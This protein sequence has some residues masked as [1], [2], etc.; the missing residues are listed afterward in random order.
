MNIKS[1]KD[2]TWRAGL[3]RR[4]VRK[5]FLYLYLPIALL[6]LVGSAAVFALHFQQSEDVLLNRESAKLKT[7][8]TGIH[9]DL[10]VVIRDLQYLV[11]DDDLAI[12]IRS[13]TQLQTT[14]LQ[15]RFANFGKAKGLY[16]QIRYIDQNGDERVRV[17]FVDQTPIFVPQGELQNKSDRYYFT[18]SR[19]L[20]A[21]AVFISRFDLNIEHDQVE[22]PRKPMLRFV[23]PV[24]V[25]G[26]RQGVMVIDY[27]AEHILRQI[28]RTFLH[29]DSAGYLL[30]ANGDWLIGPN[31]HAER[32]IMDGRQERFQDLYPEAWDLLVSRSKI[33]RTDD[34]LFSMM[35]VAPPQEVVKSEYSDAFWAIVS[36]IDA[37]DFYTRQIVGKLP[38][39]GVVGM[40]LIIF[41][42]M[43][44][45]VAQT[46]ALR[47]EMD[48][49][50]NLHLVDALNESEHR[51]AAVIEA[52]DDVIMTCTENGSIRHV[53]HAAEKVFRLAQVDLE[54]RNFTEFLMDPDTISTRRNDGRLSLHE[55]E[56][57]E[58]YAVRGTGEGFPA[59]ITVTPIPSEKGT[60]FSLFIR[61]ITLRRSFEERLKRLANY[62][63]LTGLANQVLLLDHINEVLPENDGADGPYAVIMGDLDDFRIMNDTLGHVI[64]DEALKEVATRIHKI[65]PSGSLS[66]RFGGDEFVIVLPCRGD[67]ALPG[68]V[69]D[70]ILNAFENPLEVGGYRLYVGIS[71]GV[72]LAESVEATATGLL[73][74]ADAAMYASKSAGRNTFRIFTQDMQEES[75]RLLAIQT[76]LAGARERGD[77][78]LYFQ[79]LVDAKTSRIIGAEALLRWTDAELGSVGPAEFVPVAESTGLIIDFGE[80]ALDKACR[81][82]K[83]WREHMPEFHVAV[84]ISPVQL[85][86]SDVVSTIKTPLL[87]HALAP[88][89]LEVEITEGL[90]IKD[91]KEAEKTLNDLA[92]IGVPISIDDFGTGYSS[93][94]YLHRYP[95]ATLKI[96][97]MFVMGLP[98][99]EDSRSLVTTVLALAER[100]NLKVVAEGVETQGQSE[101]LSEHGC[102]IL[103]GYLYGKP[104]ALEA[105]NALVENRSPD[106][107]GQ[108]G[109][110]G[111][112]LKLV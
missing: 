28:R 21:G 65:A 109:A 42:Y 82:A 29:S 107:V 106:A 95:F 77:I 1:P 54:G 39:L 22:M 25:D 51:N 79:P 20:S 53:N 80:W 27:L 57:F 86:G 71:L 41:G 34:G 23:S 58:T 17:K 45:R 89:A 32:A 91:P 108:D 103:Q 87:K 44:W 112:N 62:D 92:E 26:K 46:W 94:S 2:G 99:D 75:A 69:C 78:S 101:W 93:L 31:E 98:D 52:S 66:A 83:A 105:F 85:I 33:A 12:F 30:N 73:Q 6:L 36:R 67:R 19:D 100:S 55:R 61:D 88:S 16:D 76:R 56:R 50:Y 47:D 37:T 4:F 60:R 63:P 96:D 10:S 104:M 68:L 72:A 24:F 35:I 102:D 84:N 18:E 43:S 48:N 59:E 97:R 13:S 9:E 11:H 15:R 111:R 110:K 90:L 38:I 64:G 14:H 74:M 81:Y 49:Q 8:E 7:I 3:N 40:L 70:A 5:Y